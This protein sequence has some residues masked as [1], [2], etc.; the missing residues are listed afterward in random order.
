MAGSLESLGAQLLGRGTG[1]EV[2]VSVTFLLAETGRALPDTLCVLQPA[3]RKIPRDPECPSWRKNPRSG[4][5]I[6]SWGGSSSYSTVGWGGLRHG[7]DM[8][9]ST[10]GLFSD[11]AGVPLAS[12]SH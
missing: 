10:V 3:V 12:R 11:G 6:P 2:G 5:L 4:N 9:G 1:G 7:R 8:A